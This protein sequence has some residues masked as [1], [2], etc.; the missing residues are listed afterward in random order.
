MPV[1]SGLVTA[2]LAIVFGIIILIKPQIIA[3][4]I[5]IYLIIIGIMYL[6][7]THMS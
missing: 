3:W 5:G 1:I 7:Q 6:V 4:L 2:I